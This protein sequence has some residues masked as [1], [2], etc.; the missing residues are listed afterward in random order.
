MEIFIKKTHCEKRAFTDKWKF[1]QFFDRRQNKL[2]GN[3]FFYNV[4]FFTVRA[5]RWSVWSDMNTIAHNIVSTPILTQL[6]CLNHGYFYTMTFESNC[7]INIIIII[8]MVTNCRMEF[9]GDLD[10]PIDWSVATH[11]T[12]YVPFSLATLAA[13]HLL[14]RSKDDNVLDQKKCVFEIVSTRASLEALESSPH[15]N[16]ISDSWKH[17][18][19]GFIIRK[20][21]TK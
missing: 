9:F 2:I 12:F 16:S 7:I 6:H 8:Y 15:S 5:M 14:L 18:K 13:F 11:F 20:R 19:S 21:K 3:F 17:N 10:A 4:H 1:D